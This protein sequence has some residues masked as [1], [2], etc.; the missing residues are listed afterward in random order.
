MKNRPIGVSA[1]DPAGIGAEITLKALKAISERPDGFRNGIV[2]YGSGQVLR[3]AAERD[4]LGA[5]IVER[6]TPS[7]WPRVSVISAAE[8]RTAIAM[9][10][11]AAEAGRIAYA[12]VVRAAEHAKKNRIRAI[13]TAPISKEAVNLAGHR[14]AGHTELLADFSGTDKVCMMLAHENLRVTH[15]ST[16]TALANVP[17]L[18]TKE[19]LACVIDLTLEALHQLGIGSP[20]IAVAA[21]N[22][23]AGEGGLFG[24]EDLEVTAP[25]I[26]RYQS[27]GV[28]VD[29]PIPGDTVF[30]RAVAGEFDAVVAMFHDQGHIPVK[31]LGFRVDPESGRWVGL[32]G[33]N[34]T[35]GLPFVRTSVDHGTAFDIAGTGVASAQSMIDAIDFA[36][37][38]SSRN[39]A[40]RKNQPKEEPTEG[41]VN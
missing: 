32:S 21:L 24:S 26:E 11:V 14:I 22:P 15:L 19:R 40:P 33:V 28:D 18:L 29:G 41:R 23:H 39:R 27:R 16:H 1:G 9:G 12:S 20:R 36:A 3:D 25:L 8:P 30:L 6:D 34:V 2:V 7:N 17:A 37:M 10:K 31:F 13:V 35:L 38:L 4:R 5:R